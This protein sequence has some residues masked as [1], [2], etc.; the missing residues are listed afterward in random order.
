MECNKYQDVKEI[1]NVDSICINTDICGH[2]IT[3]I[4]TNNE[5]ITKIYGGADIL[6]MTLLF[7]FNNYDVDHFIK[8]ENVL[9]NNMMF[10]EIK[11][12]SNNNIELCA[13]KKSG[14]HLNPINVKP[15]DVKTFDEEYESLNKLYEQSKKK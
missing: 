9:K 3:Y 1:L 10:D 11:G 15:M 7:N 13:Y 12:S 6:L 14:D 4:N 2:N 8:Y 5:K